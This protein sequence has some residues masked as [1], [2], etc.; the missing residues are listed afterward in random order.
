MKEMKTYSVE[1]K[2]KCG[3]GCGEEIQASSEDQAV[4]MVQMELIR[5]GNYMSKL[6]SVEDMTCDCPKCDSDNGDNE[7]KLEDGT[8][9]E[10]EHQDTLND[11]MG[12]YTNKDGLT[13][14]EAMEKM[15]KV[16]GFNVIKNK[17]K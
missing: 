11:A 17:N 13:L 16:K 15:S 2:D 3:F 6:V 14:E 4:K 1:Y 10:Q 7:W 12:S 8:V 9:L 5:E